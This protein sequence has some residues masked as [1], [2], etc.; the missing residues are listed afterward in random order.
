MHSVYAV[1]IPYVCKFEL[2]I[3]Y[4]TEY[5]T[6][7]KLML[8]CAFIRYI[9]YPVSKDIKAVYTWI[10]GKTGKRKKIG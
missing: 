2:T 10:K 9:L 7:V 1:N 8:L 5:V 4:E 6:L 3:V